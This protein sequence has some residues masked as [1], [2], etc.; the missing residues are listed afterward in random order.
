MYLKRFLP[1]DFI[2]AYNKLFWYI[3][4]NNDIPNTVKN[5]K[6]SKLKINFYSLVR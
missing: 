2:S 4:I 3:K 6:F 1:S 5:V